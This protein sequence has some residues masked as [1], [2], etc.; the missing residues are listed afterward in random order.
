MDTTGHGHDR[1]TTRP[2]NDTTGAHFPRAYLG[3]SYHTGAT[4]NLESA[5]STCLEHV[6]GAPT[7]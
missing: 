4:T 1:I 5:G 6:P 7:P 3:L 2:D